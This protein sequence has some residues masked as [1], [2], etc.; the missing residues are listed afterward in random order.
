MVPL[1]A[2]FALNHL[3]AIIVLLS[4]YTVDRLQYNA[5][6]LACTEIDPA[7]HEALDLRSPRS[8][9]PPD[10]SMLLTP[11]IQIVLPR[12]QLLALASL[13][14]QELEMPELRSLVL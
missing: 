12:C 14:F 1:Q 10:R 5:V 6:S 11:P 4:A 8:S 2:F 13:K 7:G 9:Y 3:G